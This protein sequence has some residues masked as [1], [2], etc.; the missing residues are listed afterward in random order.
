MDN[1]RHVG[2]YVTTR[3]WQLGRTSPAANEIEQHTLLA[4]EQVR[5]P[6][7]AGATLPVAARNRT[8]VIVAMTQAFTDYSE[9]GGQRLASCF[10]DLLVRLRRPL[11]EQN[12]AHDV[13]RPLV[14]SRY[15]D[16]S[17]PQG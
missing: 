15:S 12:C 16:A 1:C 5:V 8:A 13:S 9:R 7:P 6:P 11:F 14:V 2:C 17:F 3:S 4:R 10:S